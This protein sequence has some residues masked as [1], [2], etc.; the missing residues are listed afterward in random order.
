MCV[1]CSAEWHSLCLTWF[2]S[3]GRITC[4]EFLKIVKLYTLHNKRL[5]LDALFFIS[6]YS[7]QKCCPSLI[8]LVWNFFPYNFRT[9][10]V[11]LGI[12]VAQWLRCCA[13][14]WK[15]AGSIAA[16]V[17]EIFCWHKI[18]PIALW[19]RDWLSLWQKWVPAVFTGGKKWP[20]CKADN[21]TTILGHCHVIWE[22][23]FPGTLWAPQACNGTDLPLPL[24][25][26]LLVKSLSY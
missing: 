11:L 12:A 4:R 21:L 3:H 8:L 18:L 19:P 5:H 13:T 15:V 20:V 6:V 22:P 24:C 14:N 25:Y 26:L 9:P 17:T 1:V 2:F 7:G 10:S 16:G 23:N